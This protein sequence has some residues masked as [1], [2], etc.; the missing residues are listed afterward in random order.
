MEKVLDSK[1]FLSL[2]YT[3]AYMCILAAF[4]W[5]IDVGWD[6]LIHNKSFVEANNDYDINISR[7]LVIS[8]VF[9]SIKLRKTLVK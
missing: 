3:L 8:V 4:S 6:I 5:C 7:W 2:K 1:Y 9:T